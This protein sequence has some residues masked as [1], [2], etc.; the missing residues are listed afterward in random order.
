M[1]ASSVLTSL[2]ATAQT[3]AFFKECSGLSVHVGMRNGC[4]I[5]HEPR[6]G[7]R[8]SNTHW[9]SMKP[10]EHVIS[11]IQERVP[12][13]G[14]RDDMPIKVK[15]FFMSCTCGEKQRLSGML[16]AE[17]EFRLMRIEHMMGV[18]IDAV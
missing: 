17:V 5:A 14:L 11:F 7:L 9:V 8:G 12:A 1:R 2:R 6:F 13:A 4:I 10:E 3:R 16:D 15:R 18:L